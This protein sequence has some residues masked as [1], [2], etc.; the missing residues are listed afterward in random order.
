MSRCSFAGKV[1]DAGLLIQSKKL[2]L[3][4]HFVKK[5]IKLQGLPPL[6]QG[7]CTH[8]GRMKPLRLSVLWQ[9]IGWVYVALVVYE[10]LT[11]S[12]PEL[13]GFPGSD[14]L[15]HFG[16]Y[17]I[18]MLW[19]GFIYEPGKRLLV[20]GVVFFMLGMMLEF[21]Q[22]ATGY[23]SMELADMISNTV[24]LLA[25]GLLAKTR[26]SVALLRLEALFKRQETENP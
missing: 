17:T 7:G 24:G 18:M 9:A 26:L 12:P 23:R 8:G 21:A 13:P 15:A 10:S 2:L 16:L 22:G 5:F 20:L 19:F 4:A 25:G 11:P 1:S 14:K 3:F 6:V